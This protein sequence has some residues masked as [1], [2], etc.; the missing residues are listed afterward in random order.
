M[1]KRTMTRAL[2]LLVVAVV[3]VGLTGCAPDQWGWF[4]MGGGSDSTSSSGTS[5][6]AGGKAEDGDADEA[7]GG[8]CPVGSWVIDNEHWASA[9]KALVSEAGL[10]SDVTV[11]GVLELDWA[12]DGS[13]VITARDSTYTIDGSSEGTSYTQTVRHNGTE[14]GSWTTSNG[15]DYTLTASGSTGMSSTVTLSTAAGTQ[16][17]DQNDFAPDP[18]SGSMLVSC[19]AG[20]MTTTVTENGLTATVSWLAR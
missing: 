1:R 16:V 8:T 9:L 18:W 15:S 4:T 14:R 5:D 7:L 3:A 12:D 19:A 17:Y 6:D 13:Y 2:S 11:S 10:V 20:G